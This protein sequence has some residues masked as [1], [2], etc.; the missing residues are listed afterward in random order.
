MGVFNSRM[1]G[2]DRPDRP[3]RGAGPFVVTEAATL[4]LTSAITINDREM[5]RQ[6]II[7]GADVNAF[8]GLPLKLAIQYRRNW[9]IATL[10]WNGADTNLIDPTQTPP[11]CQR[12]IDK[13]KDA[14]MEIANL[15]LLV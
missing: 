4:T 10:M 14:L 1:W 2:G 8:N 7:D 13:T 12:I 11:E 5:V 15:G 3:D 6:A 9:I